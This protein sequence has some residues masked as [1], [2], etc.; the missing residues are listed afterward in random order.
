MI[1]VPD[2]ALPTLT[3]Y[4]DGACPLCAAEITLLKARN[5]QGLLDFVDVA[6]SPQSLPGGVSCAQALATMHGRLADGRLLTGVT[7]FAEAYRRADLPA[8]AWLFSRPLLQPALMAG[9]RFFA[10]HRERI[11]RSL[12]P[13]MLR[14]VQRWVG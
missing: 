9:Y 4:F 14:L 2:A 3:L 1:A 5:R 13:V 11:S 6:A 7:V 12:G 8:L 10:R